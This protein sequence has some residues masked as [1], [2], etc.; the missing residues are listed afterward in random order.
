[1]GEISPAVTKKRGEVRLIKDKKKEGYLL[2]IS[3]MNW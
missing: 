2:R 3:I 1:M